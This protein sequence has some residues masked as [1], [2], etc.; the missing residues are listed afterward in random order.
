MGPRH[1]RRRCISSSTTC[2]RSLNKDKTFRYAHV[3]LLVNLIPNPSRLAATCDSARSVTIC[4]LR[5]RLP[6]PILRLGPRWR[7]FRCIERFCRRRC[8]FPQLILQ[9][10]CIICHVEDDGQRLSPRPNKGYVMVCG[11][12]L[13]KWI[14]STDSPSCGCGE[15]PRRQPPSLNAVFSTN[16]HGA[17]NL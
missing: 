14:C 11:K 3:L 7:V 4:H 12:V 17:L 16:A 9:L 13:Q 2:E 1:L 6:R 5:Q 10:R 15:S 8:A